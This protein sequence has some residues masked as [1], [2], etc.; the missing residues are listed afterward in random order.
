[1]SFIEDLNYYNDPRTQGP[2]GETPVLYLGDEEI[3]L[4]TH[5]EV[6]D[7]CHGEGS[8]VNPAIDCGGLG[9]EFAD[10]P[11]FREN[12][13]A[14]VYDVPCNRCE[15]KRVVKAVN[16]DALSDEHREAYEDQVQ[17]RYDER[18]ESLA[19]LRCGA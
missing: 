17:A 8:H 12:Y 13:L 9:D 14:G 3:K 1:M 5:W 4:P 18:M 15:G 16:W 6:C 7:L 10:D 11:E 19:E 2:A